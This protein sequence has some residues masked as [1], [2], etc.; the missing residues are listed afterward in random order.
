M[1]HKKH[2]SVIV[3]VT[4]SCNLNC[5]YCYDAN[6]L[7]KSQ[8]SLN[9]LKKLFIILDEANYDYVQIIWHGGEPMLMGICFYEEVLKLQKKF[10]GSISF[11][12]HMQTNGTLINNEWASF[13]VKNRFKIGVSYDGGDES[14]GRNLQDFS[15]RGRNLIA[16]HGVNCGVLNVINSHNIDN[17]I[18]LYKYYKNL[19]ISVQFNY[20]FPCGRVFEN[21][22]NLLLSADKYMS[23]MCDL[24]DIW[25][26]DKDCNISVEPLISYIRSL[27]GYNTKCTT[28]GCLHNWICINYD[29]KIYPCAK[30]TK[31]EYILNHI[32]NINKIEDIF[33]SEAYYNLLLAAVKRRKKCL[34]TCMLFKYCRG[35]CNADAD[36][37]GDL[38]SNLHNACVFYKGVMSH[39]ISFFEKSVDNEIAEFNPTIRKYLD[40]L[41]KRDVI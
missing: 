22:E 1:K 40:K 31:Q 26:K 27:V 34:D 5:K 41:F 21:N 17:L 37:Y 33:Y 35:G 29:G 25:I 15:L 30:M 36:L 11:D 39:I 20:I 6:N 9:Y 2:I 10:S 7:K 23:S 13:F 28:E 12:N 8:I 18:R 14:S 4:N 3:K 38:S 24:F 16:Q 32:C 19:N